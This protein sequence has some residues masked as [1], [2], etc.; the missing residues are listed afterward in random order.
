MIKNKE[1]KQHMHPKNKDKQ[2]KTCSGWQKQA[3]PW[4]AIIIIIYAF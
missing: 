2:K 4:L 3:K 1:T